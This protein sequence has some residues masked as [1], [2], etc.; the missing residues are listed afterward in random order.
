MKTSEQINE[1][2]D[3]LAKAQG[4][5]ENA[6]ADSTNPHFKSKYADLASVRAAIQGP[7]SKNGLAI[8]QMP[9]SRGNERLLVT[10]LMHRS[11]QW[12]EDECAL[13]VDKPTMQGLGSAISYAKRYSLAAITGVAERDD[14][15]NEAEKH[16]KKPEAPSVKPNDAKPKETTKVGIS[17]PQRKLLWARLKGLNYSDEEAKQFLI[18]ASG[19]QSSKEYTREDFERVLNAIDEIEKR[20]PTSAETPQNEPSFDNYDDQLGI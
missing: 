4:E 17:E 13:L 7:L 2:A 12:I 18:N 8:L 11:G 20:A 1:L 10:R 16:P 14:D 15:G 6:V 3:A 19:K 9:I 5:I